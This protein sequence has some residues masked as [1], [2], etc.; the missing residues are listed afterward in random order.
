MSVQAANTEESLNSG[1]ISDEYSDDDDPG[2]VHYVKL[3]SG[4]RASRPQSK[5]APTSIAQE[6]NPRVRKGRSPAANYCRACTAKNMAG[7]RIVLVEDVGELYPDISYRLRR[8]T[9]QHHSAI[10]ANASPVHPGTSSA[11]ASSSMM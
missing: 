8:R 10:L 11:A 2:L 4:V 9:S 7:Y 6:C 3:V 1:E 5:F